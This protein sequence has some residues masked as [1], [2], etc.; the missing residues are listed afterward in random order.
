MSR[1]LKFLPLLTCL[2]AAP[3]FAADAPASK[4]K[5]LDAFNAIDTKT[6]TAAEVKMKIVTTPDPAHH[7]ALEMVA[8]F[9]KPGTWP[10]V[11]KLVP[12]GIM[13]SKKYSGIRFF[14]KSDSETVIALHL[15]GP[16]GK[17]NRPM[18]YYVTVKGA[19]TWTEVTLPFS[20]F[21]NYEVKEWKNG[22]QSIWKGGEPIAEADYPLIN[23]VLFVFNV[24]SRGTATAGH[25]VVDGLTLLEN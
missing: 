14:A 3:A 15:V 21:K 1:F 18:D 23:A 25:F 5:V 13:N 22:V 20:G 17:D 8:D 11:K 24:N 10:S 9:A 16:R 6:L 2:V 19:S 12:P 7:K 4:T